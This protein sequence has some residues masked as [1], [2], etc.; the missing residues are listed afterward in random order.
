MNWYGCVRKLIIK[1]DRLIS[2]KS[3]DYNIKRQQ[4]EI[5]IWVFKFGEEKDLSALFQVFGSHLILFI[6]ITG[7][8]GL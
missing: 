4:Q 2:L 1:S 3:T 5:C 7:R 8:G 6:A